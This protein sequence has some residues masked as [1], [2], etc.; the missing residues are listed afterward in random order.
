MCDGNCLVLASQWN[1]SLSPPTQLA[2]DSGLRG[3]NASAASDESNHRPPSGLSERR[4]SSLRNSKILSPRLRRLSAKSCSLSAF[5]FFLPLSKSRAARHT[6]R[7]HS[8]SFPRRNPIF[9]RR[10]TSSSRLLFVLRCDTLSTFISTLLAANSCSLVPKCRLLPKI[11]PS[12]QLETH[13]L[14]S[15]NLMDV[16][17]ENRS[18]NYNIN[19]R[20]GNS[21]PTLNCQK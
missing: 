13:T 2:F 14:E 18:N 11:A 21:L 10:I 3:K 16:V 17:D 7:C 20:I 19:G 1:W 12:W 9:R 4:V 5:L 6:W 15:M 8:S